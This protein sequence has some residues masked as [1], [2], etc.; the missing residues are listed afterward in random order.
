LPKVS[1]H[2]ALFLNPFP[3]GR[4]IFIKRAD[5]LLHSCFIYLTSYE[6]SLHSEERG[7]RLI[8]ISELQEV[9]FPSPLTLLLIVILSASGEST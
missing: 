9:R 5:A 4:E 2:N 6:I 3:R 8:I 7:K 1:V